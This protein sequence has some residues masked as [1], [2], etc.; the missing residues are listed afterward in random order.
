MT[1][2]RSAEESTSESKFCFVKGMSRVA[3]CVTGAGET[4]IIAQ[5]RNAGSEVKALRVQPDGSVATHLQNRDLAS[6]RSFLAKPFTDLSEAVKAHGPF[7]SVE[8]FPTI[9]GLLFLDRPYLLVASRVELGAELP[10]RRSIWNL[11]RTVWIP[12]AM[13][14]SHPIPHISKKDRSRLENLLATSFG[15]GYYYCDDANV[16]TL[17]PFDSTSTNDGGVDLLNCDWSVY[18]RS[19]FAEVGA[20]DICSVLVRGFV[21]SGPLVAQ[22][23]TV[24]PESEPNAEP[25]TTTLEQLNV[26]MLGRQN[27]ANPGPRYFGRGLDSNHAVGNDHLYEVILWYYLDPTTKKRV[28]WARHV[29][30]RGTVPLKFKSKLTSS[31]I[32][33]AQLI[34][35]PDVFDGSSE[36]L[37]STME[38]LHTIFAHAA[39]RDAD[40]GRLA[41][42]TAVADVANNGDDEEANVKKPPQ[43]DEKR[44]ETTHDCHVK[45]VRCLNLLKG[46]S[47][48]GEDKLTAKFREIV[49]NTNQTLQ[50]SN[51]VKSSIDFETVD[52][53]G[54]QKDAGISGAVETIW[55]YTLRFMDENCTFSSGTASADNT[56]CSPEQEQ[57]AFLRINCADSLDRTNVVAFFTVAQLCMK[58]IFGLNIS[59]KTLQHAQTTPNPLLFETGSNKHVDPSNADEDNETFQALNFQTEIPPCY[60]QSYGD[61]TQ[62]FPPSLL[63]ILTELFVLNGDCVAELY[64]STGALHTSVMR[65]LVPGMKAAPSNAII[66]TQ[67]RYENMFKDKKKL[68]VLETLLG[69]RIYMHFPSLPGAA[70]VMR[71]PA[72]KWTQAVVVCRIPNRAEVTVELLRTSFSQGWTNIRES[73]KEEGMEFA[74]HDIAESMVIAIGSDPLALGA[75]AFAPAMLPVMGAASLASAA[76]PPLLQDDEINEETEVEPLDGGASSSLLAVVLF[77]SASIAAEFKKRKTIVLPFVDGDVIAPISEYSYCVE[78]DPNICRLKPRKADA[79]EPTGALSSLLGGFKK[80]LSKK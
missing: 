45:R 51:P 16:S 2:I 19:P 74:T 34:L 50:K 39:R 43:H 18:L 63:R 46:V 12:V 23:P 13:A 3:V 71:V 8:Y 5:G 49:E 58:M 29:Y 6:S 41:E 53:L 59:P 55:H 7:A 70:A 67:R 9:F 64:T 61:F 66:S 75:P 35:G 72:D 38:S 22:L 31:G 44:E 36:Y 79:E 4:V 80:M 76:P 30:L 25:N 1:Q 62:N 60:Y 56:H 33:E 17:F 57:D 73:G 47:S 78:T 65:R 10:F 32:G 42:A 26:L 20:S 28:R 52:W 15:E 24:K 14:P 27:R 37:C 40:D 21:G 54:L 77:P 48:A 68:R 11:K 69:R